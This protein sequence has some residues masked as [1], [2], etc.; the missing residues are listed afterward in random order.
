MP[1]GYAFVSVQ[2]DAMIS[3]PLF[4]T[5]FCYNLP[6][7]WRV[8]HSAKKTTISERYAQTFQAPIYIMRVMTFSL[9]LSL[10][11]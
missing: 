5:I 10:V 11:S 8:T 3:L 2:I 1:A 4:F 7:D 9:H 6:L